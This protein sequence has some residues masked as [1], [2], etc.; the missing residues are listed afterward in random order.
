MGQALRCVV[1]AGLCIVS[2]VHHFL[3][4]NL[5]VGCL[6]Q[7]FMDHMTIQVDQSQEV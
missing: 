6:L 5:S 2:N 1:C 3:F 7:V 4:T